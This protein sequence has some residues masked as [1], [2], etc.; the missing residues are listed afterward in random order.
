MSPSSIP[1]CASVECL[2]QKG[3][4][5]KKGKEETHKRQRM[6]QKRENDQEIDEK[7]RKGVKE[8]VF[9]AESVK[10]HVENAD[11]KSETKE[12]RIRFDENTFE[13]V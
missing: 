11:D 6:C 1:S 7:E 3:K 8:T 13:N 2:H 12:P 5:T 4:E 10:D 9:E